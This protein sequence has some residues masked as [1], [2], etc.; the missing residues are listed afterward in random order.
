MTAVGEQYSLLKILSHALVLSKRKTSSNK[1]SPLPSNTRNIKH[2]DALAWR[3]DKYL[4]PD[5]FEKKTGIHFVIRINIV[6][7]W[8]PPR[9]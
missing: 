6:S 9:K 4:K 5:K 1:Y 2:M 8:I 7:T 3:A